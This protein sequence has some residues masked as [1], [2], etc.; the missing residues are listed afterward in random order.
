[1]LMQ[2][3][4]RQDVHLEKAV[5]SLLLGQTEEASRALELSQEREPIAYIR[6]NSQDSPDPPVL[7]STS[8]NRSHSRAKWLH[9]CWLLVQFRPQFEQND[10]LVRNS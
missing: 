2:L 9:D 5:C 3:G 10:W 7:P 1:M 6:E 4:R 8:I